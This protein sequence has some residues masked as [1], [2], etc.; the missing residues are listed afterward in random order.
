MEGFSTK[1]EGRGQGLFIVKRL[2][3]RLGGSITIDPIDGK[4]KLTIEIPRHRLEEE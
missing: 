2:T 4:F 3:E 1:Q